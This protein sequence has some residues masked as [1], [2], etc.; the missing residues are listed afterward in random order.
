M[1]GRR[2]MHLIDEAIGSGAPSPKGMT[3]PE[4]V[5]G[6]S[7]VLDRSPVRAWGQTHVQRFSVTYDCPVVFTRGA[8]DPDN[9]RLLDVLCRRE[10]TKKHRLAVFIDDG[11]RSAYPQLENDIARYAAAHSD[12]LE[13]AGAVIAVPGG[14]AAKNDPGLAQ[15]LMSALMERR[16]D[17]HSYAV[18][19]GGGAVLDAVGYAAAIF[20]RGVRLVR[21]PTTVLAQ[22][23]SGVGVKN[24]VNA[25][26]VKNLIGTFA[27]PFAV[28]NDGDFIDR[29]PAREKRAGMAEAVKVALIRDG[30]FFAWIER[31]A[32]E[33]AS[34]EPDSLD[35]LIERC[36]ELHMRQIAC[37][38][39]PFETGSSRPLDFGHW[40]AH[41]LEMLTG[42]RLGHGEAVAIGIALDARYSVLAG[43]LK[44]GGD[45]RIR[46]LLTALGFH[47]WDDALVCRD[48]GGELAVLRGLRDFQEHLGGELTITLLRDIGI[49][50]DLHEMNV[51]LV[52]RA[53][54]WLAE[55][56]Y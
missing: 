3:G 39:D 16:I 28:I 29:L 49:G 35:C 34:F 5:E 48:D 37:G 15:E 46:R 47:L 30:E 50:L 9:P 2:V 25:F 56:R 10:P 17:R 31:R 53:I 27:P 54:E 41:K 23:D 45:E 8:F 52:E 40:A 42:H 38:G 55:A 22:D 24:A 26:G 43:L 51:A 6:R 13:I 36:A 33:L 20:H 14:E 21:F 11:V 18:V 44:A 7:T 19:I 1:S 32:R 4:P 12:W